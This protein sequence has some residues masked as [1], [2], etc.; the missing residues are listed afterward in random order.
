MYWGRRDLRDLEIVGPWAE[1]SQ[2]QRGQL[3][4]AQ[5]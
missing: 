4:R 3:P 5:M 1:A 2:V